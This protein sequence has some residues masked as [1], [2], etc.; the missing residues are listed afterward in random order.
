MDGK[1]TTAT[2]TNLLSTLGN[3]VYA[4][5]TPRNHAL[6]PNVDFYNLCCSF[7]TNTIVNLSRLCCK[8]QSESLCSRSL[9]IFHH[10]FDYLYNFHKKR[11]CN[12]KKPLFTHYP[13]F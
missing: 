4:R 7:N 10:I 6:I 5:R 13:T 2:A 11:R 1:S 9:A 12:G 3:R 8:D